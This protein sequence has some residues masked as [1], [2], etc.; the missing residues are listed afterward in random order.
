MKVEAVSNSYLSILFAE[1]S[2]SDR[3]SRERKEKVFL[4]CR[5]SWHQKDFLLSTVAEETNG[6]GWEPALSIKSLFTIGLVA[7]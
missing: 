3:K 6:N 5:Y 1:L 7:Q 2:H 4:V